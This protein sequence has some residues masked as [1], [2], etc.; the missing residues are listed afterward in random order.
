MNIAEEMYVGLPIVAS[1]VRGH[2]DL[3]E[4]GK[5]GLLFNPDSVEDFVACLRRYLDDPA[6]AARM[7]AAARQKVRGF[8]LDRSLEALSGIYRRLLGK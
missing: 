2:R 7:A 8:L 5:T 3:I 4:S 6:F 1:D